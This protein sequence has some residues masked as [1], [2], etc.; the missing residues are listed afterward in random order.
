MSDAALAAQY[1]AYPYPARDPR[2]EAKRLIL[3]SP[4]HLVEV[5]HFVFGGRRDFTRP[6]RALVAG[7]GTGDGAI[8]LAQQLADAAPSGKA[9]GEV[10]Y[11][12]ASQA[13]RGIAEARA[14]AR[15]LGN[16]RFVTGS[17]LDV[18]TL[19]PGLYDYI[20]CCGVLHHLADP[21]A[22]LAALAGV[23]APDGGMGL[24]VYAPLGRAGV[25][26]VQEILRSLAPDT[27]PP[28][29]RIGTARRLVK[30]LPPTNAFPRN[31]FVGDHLQ[32]GDAGLYDLLLNPRDRAYLV[33]EVLALT[34]SAGLRVAAFVE[35][36]RYRPESYVADPVLR[37]LIATIPPEVQA[38]MAER[39]AGNMRK[40]VWYAVPAGS[41]ATIAD[42]DGPDTVPVLR[43]EDG[44][45]LARGLRGGTLAATIDGFRFAFPLPRRASAILSRI[46][47]TASLGAIHTAIAAADKGFGW[48]AFLAEFR[49]VFEAMHG[50]NK[51]HLR[52][53][54]AAQ[55]ARH[56]GNR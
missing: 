4:S 13:A 22:G 36:C 18:A 20:D 52:A 37:R 23:L 54:T 29:E 46:D 47:N 56:K 32:G 17:L 28:A 3:G 31:P 9:G 15:D 49:Q 19:A 35:P 50:L 53:G 11:L 12:D 25:Y 48:E 39:L 42:I 8:M 2:D 24:M 14:T 16:I 33:P 21:T 7:G 38:A 1:E 40:H 10:V 30:A 5:N 34:A 43:D 26:D 45:T 41:G 51:L 27:L 44:A 55:E 6:F